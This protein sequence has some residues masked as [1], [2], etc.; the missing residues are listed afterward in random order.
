MNLILCGMMGAGKTTVGVKIAQLIGWRCLDTDVLITEKHGKISDIFKV[1]GEAYFRGLET[2]T[3]AA[4][5]GQ[6]RL[7]IATGGG[8]VLKE[9][10]VALLK[11][12]GKIVYL[13]AEM[14]TL[15][16]RLQADTTRPLLQTEEP[17]S[18]RLNRLLSER[19]PVY[20]WV[21]DYIVDVDGK[22]PEEIAR[23]ILPF[24]Q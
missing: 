24:I 5:A 6:D 2:E 22:D 10:N 15:L 1:H 17:L 13:R 19:A 9:E 7:V 21:A 20:E 18:A 23:E 16:Q 12:S 11:Q 3:V 8:L 4:L 14:D